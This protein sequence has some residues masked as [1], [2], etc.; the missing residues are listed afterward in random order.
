MIDGVGA[1]HC[2]GPSDSGRSLDSMK[3]PRYRASRC[4]R[5]ARRGA[6]TP[7]A[8]ARQP[9]PRPAGVRCSRGCRRRT[10]AGSAPTSATIRAAVLVPPGGAATVGSVGGELPGRPLPTPAMPD[11]VI[12]SRV[13]RSCSGDV[14]RIMTGHP[15]GLTPGGGRY[16]PQPATWANT[17]A[18]P[19]RTSR[20]RGDD[21]EI[22]IASARPPDH[23]R[24]RSRSSSKRRPRREPW[25]GLDPFAAAVADE[26]PQPQVFAEVVG[27]TVFGEPGP[28]TLPPRPP[29][30]I[31]G[32]IVGV[33]GQFG[34]QRGALPPGRVIRASTGAHHASIARWGRAGAD[35]P[36]PN[37]RRH[38]GKQCRGAVRMTIVEVTLTASALSVVIGG[39]ETP[40]PRPRPP[41][42]RKN[43][44][45]AG[46]R[47]GLLDRVQPHRLRSDR[48][49]LGGGVQR[50][51]RVALDP[52]LVAHVL[53]GAGEPP[54]PWPVALPPIRRER[55]PRRGAFEPC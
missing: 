38:D 23:G 4:F 51:Q 3:L 19:I 52:R 2:H 49:H 42:G 28:P 15:T 29:V 14:V 48:R 13:G 55:P 6:A 8:A 41:A 5:P 18:V 43:P 21:P 12:R 33:G 45:R 16:T 10:G 31:R 53:P 34:R 24:S 17:A 50:H 11:V 39:S 25:F 32:R 35:T 46:A 9:W 44:A 36:K 54:Q 26:P 37:P 30:F 47:P 40:A 1:Q 22:W 7:C 27:Q 20:P